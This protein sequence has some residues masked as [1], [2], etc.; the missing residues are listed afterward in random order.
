MRSSSVC[1]FYLKDCSWPLLALLNS[2][3]K[4]RRPLGR[5]GLGCPYGLVTPAPQA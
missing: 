2:R 5:R 3:M 1:D 4:M